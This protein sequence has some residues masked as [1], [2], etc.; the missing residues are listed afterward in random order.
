MK[1][2]KL[3][4]IDLSKYK[5]AYA[6]S[7][8]MKNYDM[9]HDKVM[10]LADKGMADESVIIALIPKK[11]NLTECGGDDWNDN[12]ADSNASGFYRYPKGTI[13]LGGKLGEELNL[14]DEERDLNV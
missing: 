6:Y 5:I 9:C 12:P 13:F 14:S 1:I 7:D 11:H 10:A 4:D 3:T 2:N 8:I